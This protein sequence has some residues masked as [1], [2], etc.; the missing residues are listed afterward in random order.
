MVR[1]RSE[2]PSPPVAGAAPGVLLPAAAAAG[3]VDEVPLLGPVGGFLGVLSLPLLL[4]F[5]RCLAVLVTK[6]SSLLLADDIMVL[7]AAPVR[8]CYSRREGEQGAGVGPLVAGR[9]RGREGSEDCSLVARSP[10]A[11]VLRFLFQ[12]FAVSAAAGEER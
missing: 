11:E 12:G 4:V 6:S 5:L 10:R 7:F 3:V 8:R 1:G 9:G 2:M